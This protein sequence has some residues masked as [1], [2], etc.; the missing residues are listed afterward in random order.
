M[1]HHSQTY[2]QRMGM[3]SD[4]L[5]ANFKALRTRRGMTQEDFEA[6]TG[7]S[8]SEV[9]R[10]ENGAWGSKLERVETALLA[11]G[12]DPKDLLALDASDVGL[13][14]VATAWRKVDDDTRAIV[15]AILRREAS[16]QPS[17]EAKGESKAL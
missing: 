2:V 5:A 17:N 6:E 14:E 1:L 7:M 9:S 12:V 13:R 16:R 11:A 3:L 10:L 4:L 8:Q 15:M